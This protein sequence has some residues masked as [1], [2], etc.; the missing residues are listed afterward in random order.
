[1]LTVLSSID[2]VIL[3]TWLTPRE[4]LNKGNFC[5]EILE[6]LSEILLGGHAAGSPRPVVHFDN[7]TPHRSAATKIAANFANF[8]MP[9]NQAT[10]RISVCVTSFYWA[11]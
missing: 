11:I 5:E 1:M 10:A 6:L 4:I 2:G 7:A 3:I 8:G 9:P